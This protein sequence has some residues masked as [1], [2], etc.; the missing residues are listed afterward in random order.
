MVGLRPARAVFPGAVLRIPPPRVAGRPERA[1]PAA[2]AR[3]RARQGALGGPC[4]PGGA[5]GRGIAL[6]GQGDVAAL[7]RGGLRPGGPYPGRRRGTGQRGGGRH[8]QRPPGHRSG[9]LGSLPRYPHPQAG[10]RPDDRQPDAPRRGPAGPGPPGQPRLR[11]DD[12]ARRGPVPPRPASAPRPWPSRPAPS[13]ASPW[14]ICCPSFSFTPTTA[15]SSRPPCWPASPSWPW[16]RSR[17]PSQRLD[18]TLHPP[19][20]VR[21]ADRVDDPPGRC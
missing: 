9:G 17:R 1:V 15:S 19:S 3:A 5:R 20:S 13:S 11:P 4:R 21:R 12:P 16:R 7:G 10:R 14:A 18:R 6:G 2:P 8:R